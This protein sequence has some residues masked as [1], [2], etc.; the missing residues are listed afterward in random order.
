MEYFTLNINTLTADL[1]TAAL[2]AFNSEFVSFYKIE[3]GNNVFLLTDGDNGTLAQGTL[4]ECAFYWNG[5][6]DGIGQ[7]DPS[8][9]VEDLE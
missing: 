6:L 3:A 5:M 7:G 4:R 1:F 9:D 2:D 8:Y